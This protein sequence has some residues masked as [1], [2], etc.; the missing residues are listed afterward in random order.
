[1]EHDRSRFSA[2]LLVMILVS[3]LVASVPVHADGPTD[4]QFVGATSLTYSGADANGVLTAN[5][6]VRQGDYLN[7]EIPV[8][9]VG[10]DTQVASIVL[11]V[12]QIGWNETVYFESISLDSMT[13]QVLNYLSSNQVAE[14]L[15][16]V[17][18]SINNTSVHLTDSVLIGPP[19]LPDVNVEIM[20]VTELRSRMH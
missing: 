9:N 6:T 8:E 5:S 13:A 7:L 1:M 17:E 20:I 4:V 14:G 10:M 2:P 18:L 15:L 19:P 3:A 11:N 12:S 16:E